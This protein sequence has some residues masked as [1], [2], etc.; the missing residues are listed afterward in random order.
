MDD[1]GEDPFS[2]PNSPLQKSFDQAAGDLGLGLAP[3]VDDSGDTMAFGIVVAAFSRSVDLDVPTPTPPVESKDD[4][5]I[6]SVVLGYESL[7]PT[8][9]AAQ[10]RNY[11]TD[12]HMGVG[13]SWVGTVDEQAVQRWL[14]NGCLA[15]FLV[16]HPPFSPRRLLLNDFRVMYIGDSRAVATYQAEEELRNGKT[17]VGNR[18]CILFRV[19]Q[20]GWR[21]AVVTQGGVQKSS[22]K[23]W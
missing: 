14:K 21:I 22:G 6:R 16:A 1:A 23:G 9:F 8:I 12:P 3:G 2:A 5:T 19:D 15:D 7:D 4:E 18:S 10:W 17:E 13:L 11:A 20:V